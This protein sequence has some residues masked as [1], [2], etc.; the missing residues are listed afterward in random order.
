[1]K[2]KVLALLMLCGLL[3]TSVFAS[4]N[5]EETT[6]SEPV[7]I[8]IGFEN[9]MSEPLGQALKQWQT[10]VAEQGDGSMEIELFP[11]SQLGSKSKLIDS[12]LLGEPVMT[13][14][15]GAFLC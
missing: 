13:L 11:D 1:M 10:L 14:A 5:S 8:Q 7:K 3:A 12:M 6:S 4:G 15:D 9:S 2:K